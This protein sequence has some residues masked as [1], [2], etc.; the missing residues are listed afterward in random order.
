MLPEKPPH[1][2]IGGR[3]RWTRAVLLV[4]ATAGIVPLVGC[5]TTLYLLQAA[6][7]EWHV[8]HARQSIVQVI[9]DP[10][11][12]ESV[13]EELGEVRQAR[14]FASSELGLPN[15][16]SYRTYV[17]LHRRFV[18]WNVVAA[19]VLSVEPKQWCFPI[20]GC[21][22]YRGYF[23]EKRAR[24]FARRLESRGYDVVVEGVPAYSTLGK[25]PDPVMSTMMRYGSDALTA[26]IFHE[27]AHQLLY[28]PNDS[29]FDEAFAVTVED[30]GLKRWLEF[31]G[32][33]R[34]IAIF[35]SE[36]AD[37]QQLVGLLRSTRD[38]LARL[39]ASG[40]ARSEKLKRKKRIFAH[41]AHGIRTL[42]RQLGVRFPLYDS[43][44][45]AG[46]NNADV[47]SVDTYYDCVPGFERL[48]A[49]EHGSL[50]RFYAAARTLAHEPKEERDAKLCS[51]PVTADAHART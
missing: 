2:R 18:V 32:E 11:T 12:P 8:L 39:Y 14:R 46:L 47:A 7:G 36:R 3:S 23:N 42:E 27:L 41:L 29:R 38:R 35:E 45:A 16:A 10:R 9:D 24:A 21:V 20:A 26:V 49:K 22:A 1:S 19:P 31:R 40:L 50:P 30:E 51:S 6:D 28:V 48:L 33:S 13:V 17:D 5:S 25:L 44:I 37:E 15:N 43:W 4:I 34:R